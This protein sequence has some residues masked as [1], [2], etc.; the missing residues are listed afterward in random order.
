M[1]IKVLIQKNS[2]DCVQACGRRN[3]YVGDSDS[4]QIHGGENLN[5]GDYDQDNSDQAH[6][7]GI[8]MQVTWIKMILIK[9]VVKERM[10]WFL[11]KFVVEERKNSSPKYDGQQS[12]S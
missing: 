7:G 5:V 1:L 10:K 3:R 9:L 4:D 6:R 2:H 8:V 11:I 12:Y